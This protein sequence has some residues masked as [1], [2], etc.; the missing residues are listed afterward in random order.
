M[1]AKTPRRREEVGLTVDCLDGADG[2][3]RPGTGSIHRGGRRGTRTG[4]ELDLRTASIFE[5]IR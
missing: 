5:N 1:N 4:E 3:R 2:A